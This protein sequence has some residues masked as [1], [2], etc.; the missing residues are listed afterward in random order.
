MNDKIT[1]PCMHNGHQR[2]AKYKID[3]NPR[4]Y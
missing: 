2:K 1:R 3:E 4:A